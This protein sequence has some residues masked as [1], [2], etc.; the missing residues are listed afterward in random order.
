MKLWKGQP[1]TKT[2]EIWCSCGFSESKEGGEPLKGLKSKEWRLLR[3]FWVSKGCHLC[4][5][6]KRI[7]NNQRNLCLITWSLPPEAL[8]CLI[9]SDSVNDEFL[10]LS[11]LDP[12]TCA[13]WSS[14]KDCFDHGHQHFHLISRGFLPSVLEE[15]LWHLGGQERR[16][17]LKN[18]HRRQTVWLLQCHSYY[19]SQLGCGLELVL[20]NKLSNCVHAREDVLCSWSEREGERHLTL[21]TSVQDAWACS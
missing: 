4:H 11:I 6:L 18:D 16:T 17:A 1:V 13:V 12:L 2:R 9:E 3:V 8:D 19:H 5:L 20:G 15:W 7:Y 10:I 21:G 14:S